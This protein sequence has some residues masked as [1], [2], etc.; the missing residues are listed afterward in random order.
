MTE[1]LRAVDANVLLRYLVGDVPALARDARA[2]V[3]SPRPLG[4]TAVALAE[5]A[6]TLTSSHYGWDRATVADRLGKLLARQNIVAIGFDKQE[7]LAALSACQRDT[8]PADFGDA[9][10]AASA[11]STGIVEIY[12]FD[13]RF[14]RAGLNPIAPE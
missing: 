6:W 10:I 1:P 8:A 9:L 4:L 12:S 5:V 3:D 2:L 13:R 14:A 11:R 7:G